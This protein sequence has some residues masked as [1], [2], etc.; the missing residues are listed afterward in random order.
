MYAPNPD[1]AMSS[2]SIPPFKWS[3]TAL[4]LLMAALPL[5]VYLYHFD[6]LPDLVPVHYNAAGVADGF[7]AKSGWMAFSVMGAGFVG[8]AVGRLLSVV[9]PLTDRSG[10][11]RAS[12]R[13]FCMI[14]EMF[15]TG[16]LS[17]IALG[18]LWALLQDQAPDPMRLYRLLCGVFAL[19]LIAAG[20]AMPKLRRNRLAGIRTSYSLRS[21]E[22]WMRVHRM[23]GKVS[24]L[25]GTAMLALVVIPWLSHDVVVGA[26]IA[27]FAMMCLL[28][29]TWRPGRYGIKD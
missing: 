7:G 21:D 23:G 11:N 1:T 25:C 29:L 19:F 14:G 13:R 16:L 24:V 15:L 27:L 3:V 9:I 8:W 20:N 22:N 10:N 5:A 18:A 26:S 12:L 4:E 17:A 2:P 6:R 28:T